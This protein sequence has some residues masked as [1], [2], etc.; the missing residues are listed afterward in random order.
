MPHYKLVFRTIVTLLLMVADLPAQAEE[1]LYASL[2]GQ[3]GLQHI[4]HGLM[5][6]VKSDPRVANKF[7]NINMEYL[8]Q[9]FVL[10]LCAWTGGPCEVH[11]ASMKGIHAELGLTDRN[12]NAVVEDLEAAMAEAGTPYHAQNRL[13]ALLA[14]MHRDIVS[15]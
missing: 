12:F 2:G 8:E 14:P 13:L 9:R 10:R 15:K 11:G 4:A 7:D 3:P 5:Q 1:T 6:R